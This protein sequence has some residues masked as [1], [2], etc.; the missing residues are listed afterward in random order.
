M[1]VGGGL[2]VSPST[3]HEPTAFGESQI[4]YYGITAAL[5]MGTPYVVT[6]RGETKLRKPGKLIFGTTLALTYSVGLG[7][8]VR[9]EVGFEPGDEFFRQVPVDVTAHEII[10]SLGSS[11][12]E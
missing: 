8:M 11:L 10:F 7:R 6:S 2:F 9:A 4:N 5:D 12:S 3:S 1:A